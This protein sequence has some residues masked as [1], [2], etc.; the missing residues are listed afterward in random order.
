MNRI[1]SSTVKMMLTV[2]FLSALLLLRTQASNAQTTY[3][4]STVDLVLSGTSTLHNW[5]MKSVKANCTAAFKQNSTG[6]VT[7]LTALSF[8]TPA[9]ALKSEHSSMDNNAYKTLKTD[10][11]PAITYTMTSATVT[12]GAGGTIIVQSKGKLTI[13]GTTRD[14]EIVATVKPNADNTLTVS[15]SRT[16][17][18]KDFSMQPPSFM[19]GTVKTGNDVTLTFSLILKKI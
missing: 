9:T 10:K 11:N 1:S 2:A 15:G 12:N 19:L 5:D 8:S 7:E 18:M 17:S 6:Q 16:I 4:S 3:S 13:A 14:E